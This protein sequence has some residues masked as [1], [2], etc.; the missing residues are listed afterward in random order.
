M[1]GNEIYL[2]I[3]AFGQQ[4][5]A[6]VQAR[7]PVH[8]GDHVHICIHAHNMHLFDLDTGLRIGT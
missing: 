6:R 2:Y 3:T 1:M 5:V 4:L 8:T 7:T